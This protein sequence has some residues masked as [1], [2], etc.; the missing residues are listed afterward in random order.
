MANSI[1]KKPDRLSG[2]HYQQLARKLGKAENNK[3]PISIIGTQQQGPAT[4]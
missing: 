2:A 3:Q 4:N 1:R